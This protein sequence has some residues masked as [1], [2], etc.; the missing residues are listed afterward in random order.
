MVI[1]IRTTISSV[2]KDPAPIDFHSFSDHN[3]SNLV[4]LAASFKL[5]FLLSSFDNF[6]SGG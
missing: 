2:E 5:S 6:T 3:H 1:Q 4:Q